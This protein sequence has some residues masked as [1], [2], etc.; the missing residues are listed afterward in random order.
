MSTRKA[1]RP[2]DW[3]PLEPRIAPSAAQAASPPALVQTDQAG[4][5]HHRKV[6]LRLVGLVTGSTRV[7]NSLPDTGQTI[8]LTGAGRL[9]PL[10]E[11][12]VAAVL[13][14]PG[15]IQNGRDAGMLSLTT[16]AGHVTLRFE[17][18][19]GARPV[20][21]SGDAFN[22]QIVEGNGPYQFAT[23]S[24]LLYLRMGGPLH[25]GT[26][27]SGI[28]GRFFLSFNRPLSNVALPL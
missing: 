4:A 24:G 17:R 1:Y 3:D 6:H 2:S 5:A 23:G 22:Y 7:S 21:A 10:G 15:F 28:A 12:T 19:T 16:G 9:R 11:A 27:T 25:L 8:N 20:R 18:I 14:E 26:D 13:N